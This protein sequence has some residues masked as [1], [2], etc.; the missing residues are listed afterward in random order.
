MEVSDDERPPD[1]KGDNLD[2]AQFGPSQLQRPNSQDSEAPDVH[3][4]ADMCIAYATVH[5]NGLNF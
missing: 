1:G 4:K 5:G 3:H 2:A